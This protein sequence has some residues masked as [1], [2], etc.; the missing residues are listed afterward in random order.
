MMR[1]L[2]NLIDTIYEATDRDILQRHC[3]VYY[4]LKDWGMGGD[5]FATKFGIP[6][7]YR[8]AMDGYWNMDHDQ[9]E[10]AV[11]NLADPAVIPD[12]AFKILGT[13]HARCPSPQPAYLFF[14][15]AKCHLLSPDQP[16]MLTTENL[17]LALDVLIRKD[18]AEG[19]FF[20]RKYDEIGTLVEGYEEKT[21]LNRLL[22]WCFSEPS[23][24]VPARPGRRAICSQLLLRL[25]RIEDREGLSPGL[26]RSPRDVSEGL[27]VASDRSGICPEGQLV[28][29]S[30]CPA[31]GP[32]PSCSAAAADPAGS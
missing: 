32:Q 17:E 4:L 21:L 12:L 5:E 27:S 13:I 19:F 31:P 16:Q 8:M 7:P 28:A 9:W 24:C 3:L 30:D 29:G 6:R 15:L 14:N 25:G 18:L 11:R 23:A 1:D 20:A 26:L 10:D 22:V 2:S